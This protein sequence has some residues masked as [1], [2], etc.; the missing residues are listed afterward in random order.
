MLLDTHALLWWI[1]DGPL[2]DGA[3]RAV[4]DPTND[5]VVSAASVWEAEIKANAGRLDLR[6]D[7]LDEVRGNGF[8][9]LPIT[10]AEAQLAGRLPL[11]HRDPFDRVLIAQAQL[12]GLT[13][14]TRDRV[15]DLYDVARLPA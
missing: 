11:H 15:F 6:V 14:V 8:T 10:L 7:V 1:Q 12:E 5:V 4:G 9:E 3:R 2:S 13:L